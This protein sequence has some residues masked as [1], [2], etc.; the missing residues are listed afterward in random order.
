M[1]VSVLLPVYNGAD[2]LG[3]AIASVLA[4]TLADFELIVIND[5]SKDSSAGVARSFTDPRIRVLDL[6]LNQGLICALNTGLE[7]ARGAF[8]ARMDHDDLA[9]PA[10]LEQQIDAMNAQQAVI[11]GSAI[12]PFGAIAGGAI[13]YPLSDAEIRAALPVVSPFAHP[14]VTMRTEVCRRLGYALTA[15]HCEDYDLWW[16]IA[17]EGTMMNLPQTLLNYRFHKGQ[18]S[19][20]QRQLQL[21]GMAAVSCENL[22]LQNR[23][24]N[25]ADLRHHRL[26][27]TY[28]PLSSLSELEAVGDWLQW[29]CASF[30][31]AG[32]GASNQYH[33]V[34]RGVCSR[35]PHLGPKSWSVY[36]RFLA[37]APSFRSDL[38]VL[39]SA[40][41]GIGADGTVVKNV[42]RLLYR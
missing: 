21:A 5:G 15:K 37:N 17:A 31:T 38:L 19:E 28:E 13:R 35:Q 34:W 11:C 39:L 40:M 1:Q 12:Q 22:R 30:G 9:H 27:L 16:R 36:K 25:R 4:Q 33:R 24:R 7:E 2:S 41:G 23:Y 14:T 42:R 8:L 29:L 6:A 32:T 18:I 10:R 20:T 26:A 3:A